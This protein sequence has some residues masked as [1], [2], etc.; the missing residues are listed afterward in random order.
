MSTIFPM[1]EKNK[2]KNYRNITTEL[3]APELDT[4]ADLTK[5]L[6]SCTFYFYAQENTRF[7][8]SSFRPETFDNQWKNNT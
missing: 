1:S 3:S 7:T 6:V 5:D 2:G 4:F 8:S